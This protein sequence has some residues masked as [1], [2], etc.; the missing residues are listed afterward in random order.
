MENDIVLTSGYAE[1]LGNVRLG[2]WG[3][4]GRRQGRGTAKADSCR[5]WG[6]GWATSVSEAYAID[7]HTHVR[8]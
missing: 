8:E 5:G 6:V 4:R 1:D 7:F 2:V 3:Q